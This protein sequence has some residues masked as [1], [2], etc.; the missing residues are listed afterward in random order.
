MKGIRVDLPWVT[1]QPGE[2]CIA[3]VSGHDGKDSGEAKTAKI[4][5]RQP[6][7]NSPERWSGV[8]ETPPRAMESSYG[9]F[10][11]QY[12]LLRG[13]LPFPSH[14]PPLSYDYAWA[15]N[16]S[17]DET[18]V[19]NLHGH[20][21]PLTDLLRFYEPARVSEEFERRMKAEQVVSMK[22]V[23]AGVAASAGSEEAALFLL[24]RM[25]DTEYYAVLNFHDALHITYWNYSDLSAKI[26]KGEPP[27]WLVEMTLAILSDDRYVTR[28]EKGNWQE[29]TALKI[30][31][32][33]VRDLL[34]FLGYLKC[35]KAVPFLIERVK[36]GQAD[37]CMLSALGE[38]GDPRARPCW[39]NSSSART[40]PRFIQSCRARLKQIEVAGRR[41]GAAGT[42]R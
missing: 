22:L 34:W 5:L 2:D 6:D 17:G 23:L 37:G 40:S 10:Q 28:P 42:P 12:R 39:K 14:F 13:V 35:R 15:M 3:Q 9:Q 11:E 29:G 32:C 31:S 21:R 16:A 25:K 24:E 36:S 26:Q 19:Y 27:D 18:P 8:L 33:G 4:V 38:I 7:A 41:T 30:S 20:N 1:L